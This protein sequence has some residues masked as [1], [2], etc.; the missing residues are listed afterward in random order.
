METTKSFRVISVD[1]KGNKDLT[2]DP[3]AQN[4]R[5]RIEVDL[6]YF[7]FRSSIW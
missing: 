7:S 6:V 2:K 5:E 4:L 1:K 3:K